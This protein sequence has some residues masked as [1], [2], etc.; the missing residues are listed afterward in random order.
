[1]DLNTLEKFGPQQRQAKLSPLRKAQLKAHQGQIVNACP[2]GCADEDLDDLGY[3]E[4]L[5]G[6]SVPVPPNVKP[7][8]MELVVA[9]EKGRIRV[10]GSQTAPIPA[11]AKLVRIT[12]SCR[13]YMEKAERNKAS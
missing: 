4:H 6:I 13:V 10:L 5:V 7:T 8:H 12:T 2:C 11:K 1:M 3:C 9:D